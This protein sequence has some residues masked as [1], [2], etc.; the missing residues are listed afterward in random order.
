MKISK[1]G[2]L[3]ALV[4]GGWS[5]LAVYLLNEV[6]AWMR[7]LDSVNLARFAEIV[8]TVAKALKLLTDLFLPDKYRDAASA[9]FAA[10][11]AFALALADGQITRPEID[12]NAA[13]VSACLLAWKEVRNEH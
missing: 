13:A 1:L 4:R 9:T 7:D 5:G 10:L 6:N 8:G 2:A 3:W 12:T 11:D